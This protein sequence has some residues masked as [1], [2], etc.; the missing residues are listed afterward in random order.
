[1]AGGGG[2]NDHI[3]KDRTDCLSAFESGSIKVASAVP[4]K[5]DLVVD[6]I[7]FGDDSSDFARDGECDDPRFEG[8]NMASSL[9]EGDARHDATDCL[10]AYQNGSISLIE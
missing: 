10:V 4:V 2:S 8:D 3:G 1:M 9:L 6:G 7:H 5:Q